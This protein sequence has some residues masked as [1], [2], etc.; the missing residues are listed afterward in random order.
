MIFILIRSFDSQNLFKI[1]IRRVSPSRFAQC[2][3][4]VN[5]SILH[6]IVLVSNIKSSFLNFLVKI[7]HNWKGFGVMINFRKGKIVICSD[8]TE[9]F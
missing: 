8:R 7:W 6:F 4:C 3:T 9:I 2:P 5:L 1:W